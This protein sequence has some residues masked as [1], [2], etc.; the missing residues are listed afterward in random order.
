MRP[1]V[2][3]H[4]SLIS[5]NL[6]TSEQIGWRK[7][8]HLKRELGPNRLAFFNGFDGGLCRNIVWR[9]GLV[10]FN[11]KP[12]RHPP[13]PG[14]GGDGGDCGSG[15]AHDHGGSGKRQGHSHYHDEES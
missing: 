3:F 1:Q 10:H 8:K 14:T 5:K 11:D 15:C 13:P 9:L 7:Y 12:V 6:T 2:L 4:A